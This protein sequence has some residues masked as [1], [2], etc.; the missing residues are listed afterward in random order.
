MPAKQLELQPRLLALAQWVPPGAKLADVGTDHGYLPLFALQTGRVSHAI[1]SDLRPEPLEHARRSAVA[2]GGGEGLEFRLCDGL[3]GIAPEETDC[4]V[5]AGMGAETIIAIL[6][7]APW[8]ADGAHT[9]LLQ[10]MSKAETL[11]Q[12]LA[13]HGYR[14]LRERLVEDKGTLYPILEVT[15]GQMPAPTAAQLH[16]GLLLQQDPLEGRYLD[17][18][19]EKLGR[20]AAGLRCSHREEDARRAEALEAVLTGIKT[21]REEWDHGNGGG[22]RRVLI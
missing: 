18:Q 21:M 13:E 9:L 6:E 3:D 15:G 14:A 1:A 12:W 16:G 19:L 11:R 8:T 2:Y 7:A 17:L 22:D 5:L 10:P 4:V 20:A